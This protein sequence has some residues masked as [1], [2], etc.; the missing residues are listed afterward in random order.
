M[1]FLFQGRGILECDLTLTGSKV[2][3]G[4]SQV[5]PGTHTVWSDVCPFK[6]YK[7]LD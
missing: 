2:V 5:E 7:W 3:R 1:F 6:S 4:L